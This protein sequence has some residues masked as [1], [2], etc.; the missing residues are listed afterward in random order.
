MIGFVCVVLA[1]GADPVTPPGTVASSKLVVE[2]NKITFD[3]KTCTEG[4]RRVDWG[5]GSYGVKIHGHKDGQCLFEFF[6]EAELSPVSYHL[7]K[8]PVGSGPVTIERGPVKKGNSTFSDTI[9]SF[10]LDQA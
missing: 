1:L 5:L 7:V 3:P 9:T 6:Y 2:G 10:P 4:F 8:V